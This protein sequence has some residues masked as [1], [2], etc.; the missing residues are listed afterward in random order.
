MSKHASVVRDRD[1]LEHV[2]ATLE[3]TASSDATTLDLATLEASNL[4]TAS[5]LLVTAALQ[6]EESRGCH[7]RSDF[8]AP[9]PAF[10]QPQILQIVDGQIVM[11]SGAMAGA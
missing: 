9:N 7:R 1:G 3:S 8:A 2:L 6:R 10:A 5:L 4:H 11:C